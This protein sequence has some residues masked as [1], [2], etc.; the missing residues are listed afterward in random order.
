MNTAAS[1]HEGLQNSSGKLDE[2]VRIYKAS[3]MLQSRIGTGTVPPE[4]VRVCQSR[5]EEHGEDFTPMAHGFLRALET[6]LDEARSPSGRVPQDL[7]TLRERVTRPV[8][9]LKA[10]GAMFGYALIGDLA[11]IM[12]NFLEHVTEIDQDVLSILKAHHTTLNAIIAKRMTGSG[13]Q[14]GDRMKAELKA[15]CKR[16]TDRKAALR[17]AARA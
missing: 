11:H 7:D 12:L 5:L 13:G 17:Q 1:G 15:A 14:T 6:V 8:M 16:Y 9:E 3:R 10:S 4:I 2:N